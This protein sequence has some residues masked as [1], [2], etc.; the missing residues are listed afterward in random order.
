MTANPRELQRGIRNIFESNQLCL[1]FI[2]VSVHKAQN[3]VTEHKL[4]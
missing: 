3:I 1:N 2:A 4:I